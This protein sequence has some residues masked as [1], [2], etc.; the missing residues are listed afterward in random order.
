MADIELDRP[1]MAMTLLRLASPPTLVAAP[2]FIMGISS[3]NIEMG[4]SCDPDAAEALKRVSSD[5]TSYAFEEHLL[6]TRDEAA[7]PG[8]LGGRGKFGLFFLGLLMLCSNSSTK[9]SPLAPP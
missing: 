1:Y 6:D 7:T 8:P 5:L 9:S 3:S 2:P 4:S